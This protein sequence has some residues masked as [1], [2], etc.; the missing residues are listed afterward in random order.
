[1]ESSTNQELSA[2]ER[3]ALL[4]QIEPK[5]IEAM[6][7]LGMQLIRELGTQ[8]AS[9]GKNLLISPYS[10]A[11]AMGMAYLGSEGETRREMVEALG[12]S[13]WEDRQ[14]NT[15][16]AALHQLLMHPGP[17]I[18]MGIA[19]AVWIKNGVTVDDEYKA[20]LQQAFEAEIG[21]LH[22]QPEQAKDEINRWVEKH[23][24]GRIPQMLH[25]SPAAETLMILVNA[26]AFDGNWTNEFQPEHTKD[27]DF[28]LANGS[29]VSVP[30]MHQSKQFHYTENE[31]WQA[32]RLPYG[33][34]QTYMLIV[35]PRD[36]HTLEEI[37]QQL[38]DHPQKLNEQSDFRL[39]DLSLPRFRA[40]YGVHLK[41]AMQQLGIEKAFDP[42]TADFTKMIPRGPDWQAYIGQII[43]RAVMEV[44]EH[45]TVA[46]ASTLLDMRAGSAPPTNRVQMEVN[47][48]FMVAVVDDSTGA[49]VFAGAIQQPEQVASH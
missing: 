49:W 21:P 13:E 31:E 23:T 3:N 42:Y 32:I 26:I 2:D 38:E 34:E 33:N 18:E 30:M 27:G 28:R 15:T 11:A 45:G 19:S 41:E 39:V 16:D 9:R 20:D 17:G 6:N 35:L 29:T 46:A 10:I 5:Q 47:R 40:E 7:R 25:E 44:S 22:T 43:H 24:R 14:L 37:Q 48:P 36:G 4:K 12:W 8:E 1:M